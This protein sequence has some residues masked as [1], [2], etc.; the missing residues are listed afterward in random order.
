MLGRAS[1]Q[2]LVERLQAEELRQDCAKEAVPAVRIT[3]I[4]IAAVVAI[5]IA[6]LEAL[7]E[8]VVVVLLAYVI[9]IIAV[10]G[11]L[12][13]KRVF[14]VGT[15]AVLPV[16]P[17]GIVALLIAVIEGLP[18]QIRAVFVGFVIV[19][20]AIVTIIRGRVEVRIAT[21]V[22][23]AVIVDAQLLLTQAR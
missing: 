5:F 8:V 13:G 16:C 2:F 23:I 14:V 20:A 10:V 19:A 11:I 9:T 17:P 6:A 22:V 15:P 4:F 3:A 18:E 1:F 21:E 12:I 7:A